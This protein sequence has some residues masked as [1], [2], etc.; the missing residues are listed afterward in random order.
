MSVT[1]LTDLERW[2][3]IVR[4]DELSCAERADLWDWVTT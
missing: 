3:Q 1:P 2:A 4:L